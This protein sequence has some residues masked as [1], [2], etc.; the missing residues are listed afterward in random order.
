MLAGEVGLLEGKRLVLGGGDEGF[1]EAVNGGLDEAIVLGGCKAGGGGAL[2]AQPVDGLA[3]GAVAEQ[4][5]LRGKG[6]FVLRRV[7]EQV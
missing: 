5:E 3:V 4:P 2:V 1:G 6:C 7:H